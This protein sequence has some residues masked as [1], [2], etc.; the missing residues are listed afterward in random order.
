VTHP[1]HPLRGRQ[2]QLLDY[3]QTWGEHRVYFHDERGELR[4][5]PAAWTDVVG[6]DPFVVMARGRCALRVRELLELADLV[7]RLREAEVGDV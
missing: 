7:A 3:R 4:R 6:E 5:I 1:F 2:F